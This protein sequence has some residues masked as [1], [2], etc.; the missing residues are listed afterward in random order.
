MTLDPLPASFLLRGTAADNT[1]RL[2]GIDATRIVEEAR[3]RHH[4]SKTATAALGRA[5]AASALL[6][7]VLG[8]KSDSR[9]TVRIQGDGPVGWIVSEGS[10]DGQVRGYVRDPGADLPVRGTDGKLDVRGLVGTEGELA[11]TRLLD[12]GEPYTGSVRL[13]S[14]EIAEDISTYLGVSEQI[15]NAVLLGVYEEGGRVYRAGGLLVQAMPGATDETL[16]RLEANIRGMGQLTDHL[17][18]GSLLE[19]MQTAAAGLDLVL[20]PEA[21]PVHF[22]CR[23]SR[24]RAMESLRFFA[25]TE[26]Q[27]MMDEGGQEIVCHWCGEHYHITPDEIADLDAQ[28]THA[29]A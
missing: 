26:R 2:V 5:L 14:G 6:A 24:E 29:Q 18:R 12:N 3:L 20:A 28:H 15:P 7:V 16:A 9:V 23:C 1:L 27:E 22:Q 4:L 19:T 11:V 10:V 17:R 13:V 8:K 25:P 21:Q